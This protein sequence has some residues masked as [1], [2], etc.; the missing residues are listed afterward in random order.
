MI[1]KEPHIELI[2]PKLIWKKAYVFL[3]IYFYC[4]CEV[5]GSG[6][7]LPYMYRTVSGAAPEPGDVSP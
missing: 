4:M 2:V 1:V 3:F 5:S 6:K 7:T